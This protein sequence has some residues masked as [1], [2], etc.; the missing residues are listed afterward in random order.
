MGSVRLIEDCPLHRM[1]VV[2]TGSLPSKPL[3]AF[4]IIS[5]NLPRPLQP[6]AMRAVVVAFTVPNHCRGGASH[7][8]WHDSGSRTDVELL[9]SFGVGDR[10]RFT[11][12][13]H[14][15]AGRPA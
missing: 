4:V 15:F 2:T 9:A 11:A 5:T 10:E 1:R 12:M 3:Q 13:W 14:C 6:L 8:V 7:F